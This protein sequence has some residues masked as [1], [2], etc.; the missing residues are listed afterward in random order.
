M[1]PERLKRLRTERNFTQKQLAELVKTSKSTIALYETGERRPKMET[2]SEFAKIFNTSVDYILGN[3]NNMDR[4]VE[5]KDLGKLL[6]ERD[7]HYNGQPLNDD[8]LDFLLLAL[9]RISEKNNNKIENNNN[10]NNN[11]VKVNE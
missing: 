4:K 5:I 9:E 1:F 7:F 3:T 8:D 10:N 11:K 6:K 2:L